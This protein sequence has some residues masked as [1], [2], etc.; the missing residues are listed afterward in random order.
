MCAEKQTRPH[1][2]EASRRDRVALSTFPLQKLPGAIRRGLARVLF[3]VG[4]IILRRLDD[5]A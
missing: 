3:I 4:L 2:S 1:D 5:L